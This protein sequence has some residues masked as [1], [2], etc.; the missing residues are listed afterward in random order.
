MEALRLGVRKCIPNFSYNVWWVGEGDICIASFGPNHCLDSCVT[1]AK[2]L[3]SLG[4]SFFLC[5]M[6]AMVTAA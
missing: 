6:R 3:P 1:L 4:L 2:T 5:K